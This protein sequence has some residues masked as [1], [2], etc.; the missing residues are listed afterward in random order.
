MNRVARDQL[1]I[2]IVASIVFFTNLAGTR[3]WD[4][5]EPLY[6]S[7]AREMIE[8]NDWVVPRYNG[9]Y[10]FDKPPLMFWTMMLGFQCFGVNELGARFFSAVIGVLTA[11]ATYHIGRRLFNREVGLWSGIVCASTIIFTVSARAATVDAALT[12]VI[13]LAMLLF[14]VAGYV[15]SQPGSKAL[16]QARPGEPGYIAGRNRPLGP[17]LDWLLFVGIYA[18][19]GVAVLGKGP[20]GLLLPVATL[21]LY[22]LIVNQQ[23]AADR[24]WPSSLAGRAWRITAAMLR[25]LGPVNFVRS[26]WQ[27]RPLTAA[28]VVLAVALPWYIMVDLRTNGLWLEQFFGKY[29]LG[30]FVKPFMGHEGPFY[31]HFLV[32]LI[33]FFPWSVFLGPAMLQMVRRLRSG[34]DEAPGAAFLACWVGV[35]FGFWSV[36]ST[37]LPHYVLPAYPALAVLTGCFIA[38]WRAAPA[39]FSRVWWRNAT[40]TFGVVGAGLMIAMPIVAAIL[41]PGEEAIGLVGL[42]LIAGGGLCWLYYRRA[43]W[44]RALVV[45]TATSVVF[46][47]SIFAFAAARID[48]HQHSAQLATSIF[49]EARDPQIAAYRFLQASMVYYAGRQI[50]CYDDTEALRAFLHQSPEPY[51]FTTDHF[52]AELS[53]QFPGELRVVARRPRF[54]GKGEVLV[55]ARQP[56]ALLAARPQGVTASAR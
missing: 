14:V 6:A 32:V 51:F 16:A 42:P 53:R 33:G 10:F 37:K 8:Q 34:S 48:R 38:D 3:L 30:P 9:G 54:L 46:V 13:T 55:V 21:G 47:T 43:Q 11:L 2:A 18:M 49:G 45:F 52:E 44:Q 28:I 25:P 17:W 36:C 19:M 29:N 4:L 7:C 27:L 41:I 56:A 22:R 24:P 39:T 50:P 1:W 15:R 12:L 20:V 23:R 5:D 35:W 31:Y 40:I 26:T